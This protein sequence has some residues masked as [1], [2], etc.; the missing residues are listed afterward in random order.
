MKK[1]YAFF[2]ML[3]MV[4]TMGLFAQEAEVPAFEEESSDNE[5]KPYIELSAQWNSKYMADGAVVNPYPTLNLDAY[6][7]LK[8]FHVDVWSAMDL[9]E[10]NRPDGGSYSYKNNREYRAEEIDYEIGYGYTF[11]KDVLG[12]SPLSLGIAWK[13]WQYPRAYFSH[14]N[15][16]DFTI[17]LNNVLDEESKFGLKF[18]ATI[19]YELEHYYWY[20]WL[21]S[22]LSYQITDELSASLT[23]NLYYCHHDAANYKYGDNRSLFSVFQTVAKLNYAINEYVSVGCYVEGAWALD[24]DVRAG[25][26]ADWASSEENFRAGT[27][28]TFAF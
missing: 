6:A 15:P 22:T 16:L 3:A 21:F 10:Y 25:W 24:H 8:G 4:S 9:N 18:G 23:A 26:K 19:R 12:F 27:S 20:G 5:W 17:A 1:F 11:D 28:L 7:E 14:D 2:M 13:Y